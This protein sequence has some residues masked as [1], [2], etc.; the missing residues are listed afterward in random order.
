VL[1]KIRWP[2]ITVLF[3]IGLIVSIASAQWSP[4]HRALIGVFG[5][6]LV[7]FFGRP[8][9]GPLVDLL[10]GSQDLFL[11]RFLMGVQLSAIFLSGIGLIAA[12]DLA[13]RVVRRSRI[14][15][16]V[17]VPRVLALG[18]SAALL[19]AVLAPAWTETASYDAADAADISYQ[20]LSGIT[21]GSDMA[22]VTAKMDA[23]GP[24]RVFA[25]MPAPD[26]GA[27]FTVGEVPVFKYLSNLDFDMV[28][29]TLRTASLMTDP[30]ENFDENNVG[31]YALFGIRY[32]VLPP[33]RM[34]VPRAKMILAIGPYSLWEVEGNGSD[35]VTVASTQ[36]AIVANR[37]NVGSQTIE[38]MDSSLP[39]ENV[40]E[41]VAFAGGRAHADTL[42]PD[43]SIPSSV[44]TVLSEQD[45]LDQGTLTATIVA[46][47][48]AVVVLKASFDPGW[49]VEVD[50][51]SETPYMVTP[52]MPAVTVSPGRHTVTFTYHGY[53][54]YPE[55][56]AL[57]LVTL[58]LLIFARRI[59]TSPTL[60]KVRS[61][62]LRRSS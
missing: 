52:A 19:V 51:H 36:G 13:M 58:G 33:N 6:S 54:H 60:G 57:G 38:Y 23:L 24:G 17:N 53:R 59:R 45:H 29:Y 49:R 3:A 31:D 22:A 46:I 18:L 56:F 9:L 10:P 39:G 37:A 27:S 15:E 12:R 20:Q 8:T 2:I 62:V 1:L 55:L 7:L 25:G 43:A 35:Y 14:P 41:T 11:R 34:P 32:L 16:R 4:R 61:M 40:F 26:W 5:L 42:A 47:A 30:E 48:P 28:G 44:G 50:G 21:D